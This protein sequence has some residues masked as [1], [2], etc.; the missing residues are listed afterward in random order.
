MYSSYML[1]SS[2]LFSTFFIMRSSCF[3][4]TSVLF[5]GNPVSSWKSPVILYLYPFPKSAIGGTRSSVI[6]YALYSSGG[7]SG[8]FLSITSSSPGSGTSIFS[9]R[10]PT[11]S[12]IRSITGVLNFSAKLKAFTVSS[13]V[14]LTV[15][16]ERAIT[17]WSP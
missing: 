17:G 16:G 4:A 14:S 6:A 10:C 15:V 2:K 11:T 8:L 7:Q 1:I 12:S 13:N 9:L 3:P 5:V